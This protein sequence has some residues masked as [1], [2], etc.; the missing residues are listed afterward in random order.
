MPPQDCANPYFL[1]YIGRHSIMEVEDGFTWKF[2]DQMFAKFQFSDQAA[3][4]AAL[5]CRVGVI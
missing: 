4:L 3:D 1:D 2:D 5:S